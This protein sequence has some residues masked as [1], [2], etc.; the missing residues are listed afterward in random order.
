MEKRNIIV[1]G[2]SAGGFDAFQQL[3]VRLPPDLDAAIFIVWHM[4]PS[5]QGLLPQLLAK[6][7]TM[8]VAHALDGERI[9]TNRIY[10]APPDH[11]LLLENGYVRVTHGPKE[12]RFRPAVDPLFRSAAYTYGN[13]VIG[14]ILSGALDDGTAG[15]WTIKHRGGLALVQDPR[16]APVPS[17]PESALRQ[18]AIDYTGSLVQLAARLVQLSGEDVITDD[19]AGQY[20]DEQLKREIC[21]AAD[22]TAAGLVMARLGRPSAYACPECHGVLTQLNEGTLIRYRCHT[23]HAY[24][25][26]TLL[27]A[28]TERIEDSLYQAIRGADESLM[29]LN[30]LGDQYAEANQPK[31]AALYF[32]EAQQTHARNEL[33]RQAVRGNRTLSQDGLLAGADE[34]PAQKPLQPITLPHTSLQP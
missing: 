23:G 26:S 11:H 24:S 7:T 15:L 21:I 28:L 22:D 32:Q 2:A 30:Q 19:R 34:L 25:A 20:E 17:M 16:E 27:A 13:R 3:I 29:L 9:E 31:L 10:V 8:P 4:A 5:V 1:M 14:V 33:V 12:N 18:V 6:L